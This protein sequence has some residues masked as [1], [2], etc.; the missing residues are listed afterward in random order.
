MNQPVGIAVAVEELEAQR[1]LS[2]HRLRFY[3]VVGLFVFDM[4]SIAIGMALANCIRFGEIWDGASLAR[5]VAVFPIYGI[6]A[7]V[8]KACTD[9]VLFSKTE[10]VRRGLLALGLAASLFASLL[11]AQQLADATSRIF[12]VAGFGFAALIQGM[13]RILY[14]LCAR[15]QL[16]EELY[17]VLV[18]HDGQ[19]ASRSG[20]KLPINLS[21]IFNPDDA[22]ADDYHRLAGVM[23]NMDRVVIRCAP[24]RRASWAHALQA[25]NVHA[26][27]EAP[28]IVQTRALAIGSYAG[29]PTYVV[30]R[31]P[32]SLRDRLIKRVFDLVAAAF[33]L[34]FCAPLLLL[35]ALAVKLE[36][37]GPILFKQ[38][39]IGRQNCLFEV[40]KFRSMRIEMCDMNGVRSTSRDDDRI[41][42]IGRLLR[43]SSI[44]ELPQLFN[45][46]K[47][48][49]SIVGPRPHAVHSTASS[50]LF[51]EVDG[52]YWHR[53][54][55][56]PG[57]TGLAQVRGF[58]GATYEESDLT[59]RLESD[60]EYLSNWS[61]WNDLAIIART[62]AVLVHKNAY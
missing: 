7:I 13:V 52:R 58:R 36:S 6:S 17:S 9:E 37:Q 59:N 28:E 25:M 8:L 60:L 31:G 41:T 42:R 45:V 19:Y 26:E 20:L 56:K 5:T 54:A 27:I 49:M 23:E 34:V 44:D 43:M 46:L 12:V 22:S 30:A 40:Y 50:K 33:A 35:V 57:I 14:V 11:F 38:K 62:V 48:D 51:W 16:G 2:K 47:G 32:L 55:C 61:F 10:T 18:I 29:R 21:A 39:R 3:L 24:E 15:R 1:S 4:L 53:H